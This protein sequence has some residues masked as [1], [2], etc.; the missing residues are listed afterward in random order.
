[1]LH[2]KKSG[3]SSVRLDLW[4]TSSLILF[5]LLFSTVSH[6]TDFSLGTARFSIYFMIFY[7]F[8]FII[9]YFIFYFLTSTEEG[10]SGQ[11]KYRLRKFKIYVVSVLQSSLDFSF[12]N[13]I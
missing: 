6:V 2:A 12:F 9:Y 4:F 7:L 1:M 3:I 8:I 11:Q 5:T 13:D 10:R